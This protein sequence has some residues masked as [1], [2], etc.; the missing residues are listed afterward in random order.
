M[1]TSSDWLMANTTALAKESAGMATRARSSTHEDQ[2]RAHLADGRLVRVLA[3]PP[4]PGYH[5]YYPGHRQATPAFS[6]LVDALR[7]RGKN[8]WTAPAA[9]LS[10]CRNAIDENPEPSP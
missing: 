7:H 1:S 9:V 8:V 10:S 3:G 4:F 5:L 6:L 2:L